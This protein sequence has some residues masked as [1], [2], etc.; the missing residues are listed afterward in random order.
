MKTLNLKAGDKIYIWFYKRPARE[1]TMR[2]CVVEEIDNGVKMIYIVGGGALSFEAMEHPEA[3]ES[4]I[5]Y[6]NCGVDKSQTLQELINFMQAEFDN[7]MREL[8]KEV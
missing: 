6:V 7:E 3:D 8:R 4:R 5:W 2:E 1:L